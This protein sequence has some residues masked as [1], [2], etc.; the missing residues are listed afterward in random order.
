MILCFLY[1]DKEKNTS[2]LMSYLDLLP[3]EIC[4]VIMTMKK[5]DEVKRYFVSAVKHELLKE[6]S[7]L[8]A[9]IKSVDRVMREIE[10]DHRSQVWLSLVPYIYTHCDHKYDWSNWSIVWD[11][12]YLIHDHKR[13]TSKCL[14]NFK[15]LCIPLCKV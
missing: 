2:L 3:R 4:D 15:R 9:C 12:N 14:C 5:R 8:K 1:Y 7:H 13:C 10:R 6:T 11:T